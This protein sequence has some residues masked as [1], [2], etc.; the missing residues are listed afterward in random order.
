MV[1]R[2]RV[3]R[4]Q[5]LLRSA[6]AGMGGTAMRHTIST[7]L[8]YADAFGYEFWTDFNEIRLHRGGEKVLEFVKR[9]G[10]FW[11]VYS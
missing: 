10:Y 3:S 6:D 7:V 2:Q 9:D 1:A 11:Q 4:R 8:T 5:R